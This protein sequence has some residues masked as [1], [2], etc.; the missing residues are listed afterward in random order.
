M[1]DKR[2][3]RLHWTDVPALIVMAAVVGLLFIIGSGRW[4]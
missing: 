3:P 1:S 2:P 4:P